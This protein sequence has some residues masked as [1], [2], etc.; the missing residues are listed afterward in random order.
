M[1]E[2]KKIKHQRTVSI[3]C[4]NA[5]VSSANFCSVSP[6]TSFDSFQKWKLI[7]SMAEGG[8]GFPMAEKRSSTGGRLSE[9]VES[10]DKR[11]EARRHRGFC[12]VTWRGVRTES[13]ALAF[14]LNVPR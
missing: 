3:V 8:S 6:D 2:L 4:W 13:R 5:A 9:K 7:L 11:E 1:R 12:R 14:G 10:I